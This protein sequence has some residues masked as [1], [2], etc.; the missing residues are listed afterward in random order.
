MHSSLRVLNTADSTHKPLCVYK[1]EALNYL[2][3]ACLLRLFTSW[4]CMNDKITCEKNLMRC[5]RTYMYQTS[6]SHFAPIQ[7]YQRSTLDR[8]KNNQ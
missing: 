8:N 6:Y 3:H 2:P 5:K 7:N 1:H 4:P